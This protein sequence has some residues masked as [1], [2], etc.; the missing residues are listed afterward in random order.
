MFNWGKRI[1]P[2]IILLCISGTVLGAD[3]AELTVKKVKE[4]LAKTD[5]YTE[6]TQTI[7]RFGRRSEE[8]VRLW[9]KE[10]YVIKQI[11]APLWQSGELTIHTPTEQY[12]YIPMQ[13][14]CLKLSKKIS[15]AKIRLRDWEPWLKKAV[16]AEEISLAGGRGILLTGPKTSERFKLF[17]DHTTFLPRGLEIFKNNLLVKAITVHKIE[18]LKNFKPLQMIPTG[19]VKWYS[20]EDQFWHNVSI[21][22]VQNG[23]N[24]Q[25]TQPSYLPSGYVFKVAKLEELSSATVVHLIYEGPGKQILSIFEREKLSENQKMSKPVGKEDKTEINMYQWF[26]DQ[27]HLVI[28]GPISNN[29]IKKVAQSM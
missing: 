8:I 10:D 25:I 1:F 16:K 7:F 3:E 28:I 5:Y 29:E 4:A 21:P 17:I 14:S 15:S 11:Q 2:V 23:V 20:D 24:F 22:R 13:K 9:V 6:Y 26:K 27:V 12:Y 19:D 18:E